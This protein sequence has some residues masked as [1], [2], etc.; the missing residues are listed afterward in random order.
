MRHR[1]RPSPGRGPACPS[2]PCAPQEALGDRPQDARLVNQP[3]DLPIRMAEDILHLGQFA[4]S[5]G[6]VARL[7]HRMTTGTCSP[8][9]SDGSQRGRPGTGPGH[10]RRATRPT[11][12]H[13]V[14][15]GCPAQARCATPTRMS[16][17]SGAK[18]AM[19][20]EP[21]SPSSGQKSYRYCEGARPVEGSR[22]P[23][24][25]T[26]TRLPAMRSAEP[27]TVVLVLCA[28][29][30]TVMVGDLPG[31]I[32][33]TTVASNR[34]SGRPGNG[35]VGRFPLRSTPKTYVAVTFGW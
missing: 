25:T 32:L 7:H 9:R 20:V 27:G 16:W 2:D 34:M 17:N 22:L 30:V 21:G 6:H 35:P 14:D 19:F 8:T 28:R 12:G 18:L 31:T 10:L 13:A 33:M 1:R 24:I 5:R 3:P 11:P 4:H 29:S 26:S 23:G 15:G